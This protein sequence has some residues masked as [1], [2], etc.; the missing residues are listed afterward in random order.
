[1]AITEKVYLKRVKQEINNLKKYAKK[2]Q[3]EKL[4]FNRLI[5]ESD[6]FCI[7]GQM[8]GNC[9]NDE[10]AELIKKCCKVETSYGSIYRRFSN[11]VD[12]KAREYSSYHTYLEHFIYN[13]K[14]NNENIVKYLKGE[15]SELELVIS[16]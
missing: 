6:K 13:Y 11:P 14:H 3:L 12:F 2:E 9:Y 7:Y 4:D 1:M 8:T 16:I 5:P 15:I 10:A